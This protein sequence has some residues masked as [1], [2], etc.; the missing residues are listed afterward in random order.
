MVFMLSVAD[1]QQ[2]LLELK[3]TEVLHLFFSN[4]SQRQFLFLRL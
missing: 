3:V 1:E 2:L 4:L